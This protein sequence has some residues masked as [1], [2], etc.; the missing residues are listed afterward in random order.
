MALS[1]KHPFLHIIIISIIT[2]S[3][4]IQPSTVVSDQRLCKSSCGYGGR[5]L[6]SNSIAGRGVG[7]L[8]SW[9]G[10][11]EPVVDYFIKSMFDC[12]IR[13]YR[14]FIGRVHPT[15]GPLLA[16]PLN[17]GTRLIFKILEVYLCNDVRQLEYSKQYSKL[18]HVLL[19][20]HFHSQSKPP[21]SCY[22]K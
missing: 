16:M 19:I 9:L 3:D 21:Q 20:I 11:A 17:Q 5:A 7:R 12:Y 8:R 10:R 4:G 14:I 15:F 18:L 1:T 22:Q 2:S 6:Y 13:V